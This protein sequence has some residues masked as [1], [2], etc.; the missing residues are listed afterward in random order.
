LR[1]CIVPLVK[2][3]LTRDSQN[4]L[5]G[6]LMVNLTGELKTILLSSLLSLYGPIKR[7]KAKSLNDLLSVQ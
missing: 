2:S 7:E 4:S 5:T 3:V 1:N 6:E